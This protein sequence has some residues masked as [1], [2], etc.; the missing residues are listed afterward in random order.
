M[1]MNRAFGRLGKIFR[2]KQ[3]KK[4]II[5]FFI[6][7]LFL[8]IISCGTQMHSVRPKNAI[9]DHQEDNAQNYRLENAE[10]LELKDD[11]DKNENTE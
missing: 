4:N 9:S 3:F 2:E 5:T 7:F 8:S 6:L 11:L 1:P 10:F